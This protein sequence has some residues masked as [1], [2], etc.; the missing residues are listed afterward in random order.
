VS[1]QLERSLFA[2][3]T[4]Y[5]DLL[6]IHW[7]NPRIP[8][9][10]TLEAMAAEH[11]RGRVRAIGV[12]NFPTAELQEA[13][14][15]S[16]LPLAANQVEYHP[17]IDQSPVIELARAHGIAIT[18]YSPLAHGT[19]VGERTLD[20]I[21]ANHGKT[22]AQVALRWLL[23]QEGVGV[24][25]RSSSHHNRAANL[26]LDFELADTERERIDS[27]AD[28]ERGRQIDPSFAPRWD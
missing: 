13:I 27:L 28:P 14:D 26:D 24:V 11:G 16:P 17:F 8:I 9:A 5:V 1:L 22:A 7:P 25:P 4:D 12:S 3:D 18:A 15:A 19:V 20:E 10:E 21:G 23:D 2:L 6:L